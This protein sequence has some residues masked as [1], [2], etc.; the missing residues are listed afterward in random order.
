[1]KRSIVIFAS[2]MMSTGLFAQTTVTVDGANP[3][4]VIPKEIY[5]QFSEHLGSCIYGGLWVG[6]ESDIPNYKGYR[7]DVMEALKALKVP[8]LR[9]PGGC[10]ADDYH[11]RDGIGPR[12]SRPH[13]VNSTWGGTEEDNSFGTHEFL[14]YCEL[15]GA[16]P[17]ISGNVGSGTVAEMADWVEYMT[18]EGGSEMVL[19]R[20]QNGRDKPWKVKYFGIGNE[21]W[22]CGGMMRPEYYS[23]LF[24]R[25]ATYLRNFNGNSLYKVASGASDYDYNWTRVL[26]QNIG[27]GMDGISLHYYSVLNWN[28]KGSALR[29]TDKDYYQVLEKCLDIDN[30]LSRHCA[31]M[32]SIDPEGK[33]DL[34]LD[35]WGTWWNVEE[36][37]NPGHLFQQNAMRDAMVAALSLDVF[38]KYTSRLK[39]ANIAQVV[40]VLQAMILTDGDKMLLT[41]T[42]HLF[43]MYNVHQ[44]A[45]FLPTKVECAHVSGYKNVPVISATASRDNAGRVHVSMT[46]VDMKSPQT[47]TLNLRDIDVKG[48]SAEIL[49]GESASDHNT[50]DNPDKVRPAEFKDFRIKGN[51]ITVTLPPVSTITMEIR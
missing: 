36:G 22:G 24:R 13:L 46:N 28:D 27:D 42:Y 37:T 48:I 7:T 44:D 29:F 40:N 6:P 5:G 32:D 10:F 41:P 34:L 45:T 18:A 15:I 51:T 21:A 26:M 30:V 35:E 47:L 16:E 17:Y 11:W 12:E 4:A 8:V 20:K 2:L 25:Y 23:D 1:M 3:G 49:H 19:L 14:D 33:V 31:V 43:R 50:F 39:M 9:W 38:H